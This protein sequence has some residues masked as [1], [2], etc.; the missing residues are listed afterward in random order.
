M[1]PPHLFGQETWGQTA[2]PTEKVA[3]RGANGEDAGEDILGQEPAEPLGDD[4]AAEL[5][6]QESFRL[7]PGDSV[8]L[9]INPDAVIVTIDD[10]FASKPIPVDFIQE[11]E[12]S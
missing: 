7:A 4:T 3:A 9:P 1:S 12:V 6:N 8:S 2:A 10:Q 5:I 11:V